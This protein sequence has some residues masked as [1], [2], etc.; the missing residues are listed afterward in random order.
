MAEETNADLIFTDGVIFNDDGTTPDVPTFSSCS[1]LVGCGRIQREDLL[2]R[3]F[4]TNGIPILSVLAD[5]TALEKENLFDPRVWYVEDYDLWLKLAR[6]GAVFYGMKEKLVKY[7]RHPQALTSDSLEL[8]TA[9]L[10][11]VEKHARALSNGRSERHGLTSED[12]ILIRQRLRKMRNAATQIYLESYD[13]A[14]RSG[15]ILTA[16]ILISRITRV[17]PGKILHPRW[18]LRS[19]FQCVR[20]RHKRP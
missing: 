7:R 20:F 18:L 11:V 16:L 4:V 14:I 12:L 13:E 15:S 19:L 8:L 17:A 5:R 2:R 1:E 3:L 6:R 9:E 10:S